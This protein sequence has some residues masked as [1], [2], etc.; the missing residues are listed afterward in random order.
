MDKAAQER[1]QKI[2]DG[3][4]GRFERGM[5]DLTE[6]SKGAGKTSQALI[7]KTQAAANKAILTGD[8]SGLDG[9]MDE[10]LNN[11]KNAPRS[12]N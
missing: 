5:A 4:K 1:F 9:I 10:V 12:N 2:V 11:L 7:N 8:T 6:L 3:A